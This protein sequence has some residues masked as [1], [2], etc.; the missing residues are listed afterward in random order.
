MKKNLTRIFVVFITVSL[1]ACSNAGLEKRLLSS[2]PAVR[3]HALAKL[4]RFS[5][6]RKTAMVPLLMEDLKSSDSSTSNR[7]ADALA[8]MGEP[9]VPSLMASLQSSDVYVRINSA[10]ALGT[11]GAPAISAIPGLVGALHDPHP[12]VREEAASALGQ[13][14]PGAKDSATALAEASKDKDDLVRSAAIEAMKKMG[15]APEPAKGHVRQ[16]QS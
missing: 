8:V 16:P 10:A 7:A 1:G 5:Q 9:A 15:V 6:S 13:L 2:D 4:A 14:G 12:L 3:A 11:M